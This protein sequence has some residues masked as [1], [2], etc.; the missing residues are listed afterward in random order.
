[1]EAAVS[2]ELMILSSMDR[3][4]RSITRPRGA[5]RE[6]RS[7][8]LDRWI[9]ARSGGIPGRR[10]EGAAGPRPASLRLKVELEIVGTS[11]LDLGRECG[12]GVVL[13]RDHLPGPL[14]SLAE[15]GLGRLARL[16]WPTG[17]SAPGGCVHGD[18]VAAGDQPMLAVD[19]ESAIP[20]RAA[21]RV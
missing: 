1:P 18:P 2:H 3:W 15:A 16:R 21:S 13:R 12:L 11:F 10:H 7:A 17:A 8:E 9:E 6:R 20:D 5:T 19:R 4:R 14:E